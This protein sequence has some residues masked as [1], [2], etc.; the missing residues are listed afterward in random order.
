MFVN[1]RGERMTTNCFRARLRRIC[2][3]L[4]I[5]K[6]S[7]HKIRKTYG[8]ILLDNNVDERF[9]LG[10]M[11]HS[12]VK[13]TENHYHRNRKSIAKK[14]EVVSRIPDFLQIDTLGYQKVSN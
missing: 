12:N 14:V 1:S 7:P 10:Q 5:Y 8:T 11:G 13:V 6:K 2:D 4:G 3:K 9:V